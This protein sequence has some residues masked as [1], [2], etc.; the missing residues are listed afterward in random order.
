MDGNGNCGP[1]PNE[2]WYSVEAAL[3]PSTLIG[4]IRLQPIPVLTIPVPIV[5]SSAN[6]DRKLLSDCAEW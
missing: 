2:Y 3:G 1:K 5:L 6:N 4:H